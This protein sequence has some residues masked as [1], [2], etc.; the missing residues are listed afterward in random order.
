MHRLFAVPA[1]SAA[2]PLLYEAR[3]WLPR[4]AGLP[5][6]LLA[7]LAGTAVR[8]AAGHVRGELGVWPVARSGPVTAA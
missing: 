7:V 3:G 4:G 1:G 6:A 5:L 2:P 8:A